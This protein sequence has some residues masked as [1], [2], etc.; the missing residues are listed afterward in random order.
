MHS[1]S[2]IRSVVDRTWS[3]TV[4]VCTG[5]R[6]RQRARRGAACSEHEGTECTEC[7]KCAKFT[8]DARLLHVLPALQASV[9]AGSCARNS[10]SNSNSNSNRKR[11]SD[12]DTG[13]AGH[14]G[15]ASCGHASNCATG[16]G[17]C[18]VCMHAGK[19][20]LLVLARLVLARIKQNEAK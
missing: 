19:Q 11:N 14:A 3:S 10:N 15:H 8:D 16:R 4:R 20:D 2:T 18:T 13:H 7:T 5:V 17:L 12:R 1:M 6:E 9:S